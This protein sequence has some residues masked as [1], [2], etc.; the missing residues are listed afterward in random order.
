MHIEIC[1]P[2]SNLYPLWIIPGQNQ[3]QRFYYARWCSSRISACRK[4]W[5]QHWVS[6]FMWWP[7]YGA[8]RCNCSGGCLMALNF[9]FD[10]ESS[11][12]LCMS[13]ISSQA[14]ALDPGFSK[15]V[16]FNRPG[17]DPG[18]ENTEPGCI[19]TVL[20]VPFII[21]P[22]S[23]VPWFSKRLLN[24]LVSAQQAEMSVSVRF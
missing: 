20:R 24:G 17:T 23:S 11:S 7:M 9:H 6:S 5:N 15:L 16:H 22:P 19:F 13:N 1:C 3:G 18:Y 2:R 8:R 4:S 14:I 21:R 10:V 12:R